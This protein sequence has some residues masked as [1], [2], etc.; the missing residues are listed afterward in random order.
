M[1]GCR[2]IVKQLGHVNKLAD[3][4]HTEVFIGYTEGTKVYHILD[5]VAWQVCL[6]HDVV[7]DE[8]HGWD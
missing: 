5:P 3:R 4:N 2:A 7:F 1:F 8:A 6:A